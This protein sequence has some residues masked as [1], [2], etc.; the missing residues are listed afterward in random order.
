MKIYLEGKKNEIEEFL[1][2]DLL[3]AEFKI[4]GKLFWAVKVSLHHSDNKIEAYL[5]EIK[6]MDKK[7]VTA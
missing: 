1:K 6:I 3:G 7:E 4:N 2:K 5:E